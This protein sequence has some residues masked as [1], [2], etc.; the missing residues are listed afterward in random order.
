MGSIRLPEDSGSASRLW[1]YDSYVNSNGT[2]Y[3]RD[4]IGIDRA[5]KTA[6]SA[7]AAKFDLEVV[8]AGSCFDFRL[9][10]E[11]WKELSG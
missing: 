2:T 3:I 4:R 6:A 9:A 10:Y 1:V 7:A 11:Y 8:S 5:T